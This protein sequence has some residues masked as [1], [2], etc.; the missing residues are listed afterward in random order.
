MMKFFLPVVLWE[1]AT[2]ISNFSKVVTSFHS[3]TPSSLATNGQQKLWKLEVKS[4]NSKPEIALS[5][6]AL[7]D[8]SISVSVSAVQWRNSS[9]LKQIGCTNFLTMSRGHKAH[10]LNHFHVV[11]TRLFEQ[12]IWM[13]AIP[14]RY[15]VLDQL[16]WV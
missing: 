1:S 5:V 13:L 2:L 15:S 3:N 10:L 8:K 9:S 14:S 4:P 11:T 7:L 12:T 6:N 16:V